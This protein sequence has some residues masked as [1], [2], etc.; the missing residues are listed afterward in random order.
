VV[1]V[2]VRRP[3]VSLRERKRAATISEIK[4]VA[5][6]QLADEGGAMTLRGVSREMGMTVQS[7]YHYFSSRDDLITAL[8]VDA[9]DGLAD[10][11]ERADAVGPAEPSGD[12]LVRLAMAYRQWAIDHRAEFLLIF[13]TPIPG[14][15][16]P[17][18]GPTTGAARRLATVFV[19]AV[20]AGWTD[21]QLGRLDLAKPAPLLLQ[22]LSA[23]AEVITPQ[24]PGPAFGLFIE[25]WGR[26]HGLVMLEVLH[27]LPWLAPLEAATDYYEIAAVRLVSDLERLRAGCTGSR[28]DG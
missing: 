17:D 14:Y 10:S 20:F 9:Y 26:V 11:V 8:I 28:A 1:T 13:G 15:R 3:E 16:A 19:G 6:R 21:E 22:T 27:H 5:L 23:S 12:R 18:P 4:A 7:L 24:L 25:L 2:T